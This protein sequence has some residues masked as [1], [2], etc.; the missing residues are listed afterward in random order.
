[1]NRNTL[2]VLGLVLLPAPA[3]AQDG[4]AELDASVASLPALRGGTRP[5]PAEQA[6]VGFGDPVLAGADGDAR[7]ADLAGL[8]RGGKVDVTAVRKLAP[9]PSTA[10]SASSRIRPTCRTPVTTTISASRS[11]MSAF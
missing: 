2:F 8:Y 10:K 6:F 9:L 4:E 3:L 11:S 5:Q 1:M 7:G